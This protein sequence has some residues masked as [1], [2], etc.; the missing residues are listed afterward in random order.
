MDKVF[1]DT[2]G[3]KALRDEKDEFHNEAL[4]IWK[5]LEKEKVIIFISNYIIDESYTLL[6]KRCGMKNVN[7]FR[8]YLVEMVEQVKIERVKIIDETEAWKWLE[9]DWSD[10]SYTDCVSFA[11]MKRL[12]IKRVFGFDKHFERAGFELE[13]R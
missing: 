12:G 9:N 13:K 8:N 6:R 10:L 1:W 4:E 5:K 7:L 3:V 11:L 2:S